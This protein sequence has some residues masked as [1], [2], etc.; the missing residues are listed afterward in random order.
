MADSTA[1]L[2]QLSNSLAKKVS[3]GDTSRE[4][5]GVAEQINAITYLDRRQAKARG[6]STSFKKA[7]LTD[8]FK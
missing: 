7:D 4:N 5:F 6:R 3:A 2:N 8:A 1:L